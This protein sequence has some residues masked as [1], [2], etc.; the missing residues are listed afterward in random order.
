KMNTN[1]LLSIQGLDAGYGESP[2]LR[3]IDLEVLPGQVV[4][5]MGRNGVGKT[6]LMKTIMG[7]IRP[8]RGKIYSEGDDI[9]YF[10]TSQRARRGFGYVP[11]G[12][13][14]FPYLT[15][16]ENLLMGLEATP[17]RKPDKSSLEEVYELFP[18]IKQFRHRQAGM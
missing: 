7:L 15:V 16:Y 10:S 13:G 6:T 9:T 18:M 14:I 3:N 12:R 11:Q 2:V 17:S 8:M 4:C 5:L 1:I